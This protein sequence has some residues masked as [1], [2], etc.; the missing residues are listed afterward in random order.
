MLQGQEDLL[1]P[2]LSIFFSPTTTPSM[3]LSE[4]PV[5]ITLHCLLSLALFVSRI[6]FSLPYCAFVAE[7][8][9]N[10]DLYQ[11]PKASQNLKLFKTDLLDY[12]SLRTAIAGCHGVFHVASPLPFFTAKDPEARTKSM[13]NN[14][15]SFNCCILVFTFSMLFNLN[16]LNPSLNELVN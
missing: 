11:L 15:S 14:L 10:A 6:K 13:I 2:G 5:T 8:T 4:I 9:K 16:K 3:E 7:D 1:P 12:H